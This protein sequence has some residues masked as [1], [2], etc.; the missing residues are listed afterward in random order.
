MRRIAEMTNCSRKKYRPAD[1]GLGESGTAAQSQKHRARAV[2]EVPSVGVVRD[3]ATVEVYSG[4]NIWEQ[5]LV[6]PVNKRFPEGV[7]G[8]R[9][10]PERDAPG[11]TV[12]LEDGPSEFLT[13]P[14]QIV[15][16]MH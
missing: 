16:R 3:V 14:H 7:P 9:L 15:Q 8:D 10:T 11:R 1:V 5:L 4:P 12:R 13:L 2:Q 6:S